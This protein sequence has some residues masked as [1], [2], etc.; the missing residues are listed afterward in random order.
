MIEVPQKFLSVRYDGSRRPGS[1]DTAGIEEGAN[2]QRFA[3]EL[4]H[5]FGRSIPDFRSSD[6]WKIIPHPNQTG[7]VEISGILAS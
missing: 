5:Y 2:C 7:F 3:Y 1:F 4:V 6:H